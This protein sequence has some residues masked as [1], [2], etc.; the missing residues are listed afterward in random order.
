[1]SFDDCPR[2]RK[3]RH[4]HARKIRVKRLERFVFE[5]PILDDSERVETEVLKVLFI[6]TM[7]KWRSRT[8]EEIFRGHP[9]LECR[10]AGTSPKARRKVRSSDLRWADLVVFMED[11]HSDKVEYSFGDEIEGVETQILGIEDNFGFMDE[12]LIDELNYALDSVF[13]ITS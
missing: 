9:L 6:C 10:S 1:M 7:N 12:D 5:A 3:W 13:L 2:Y 11:K 4:L 8:A